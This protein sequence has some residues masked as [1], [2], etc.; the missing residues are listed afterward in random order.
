MPPFARKGEQIFVTAVSTF[1]TGEA[2]V[3][4]A[5]IK[6]AVDHVPDIWPVEDPVLGGEEPILPGETIVIDLFQFFKSIRLRVGI[7]E[8][9]GQGDLLTDLPS[10]QGHNP[11]VPQPE[12]RR[13]SAISTS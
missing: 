5:T 9:P 10:R 6:E 4:D 3:A 1:D 11:F 2:D 7:P 12:F 8:F 13:H